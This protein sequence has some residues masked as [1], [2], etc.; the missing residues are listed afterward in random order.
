MSDSL[1][2][3]R[4]VLLIFLLII[5]NSSNSWAV[6][7]SGPV[8][9]KPVIITGRVTIQFEDDVATDKFQTGFTRTSFNLP[10]LDALLDQFGV[11]GAEAV[12]PWRTKKPAVNSKMYDL[13]RFWEI[14]FPETVDVNTVIKALI[15]NPH[16]RSAEAVW[17]IPVD[18]SPN[19]PGWVSQWYMH[20]PGP[21][22]HF[23]DAWDKETG[24]DSIIFACVDV[25]VCYRHPDLEGNIWVNPGEDMDSDGVVFDPDDLNGIDDD[26]NGRTDDLIG[27][28]FFS[29]FGGGLGIWPGEDPGSIDPDPNDFN[30]HGTNVSGIAVAMNNNATGVTGEAG[31]WYGGNRAFRGA[32]IMCCRVG[33]TAND[34]LGYV[35]SDNCG[36]AID[37]AAM[38]GASVINASWGSQATSTMI[39]GMNNATASGVS[40]FHAAG[41]ANLDSPDYLDLLGTRV[42]SVAATNSSDHKAGFSNFGTWVDVS[43]PG[44]DIWNTHSA[45]YTPSYA[46]Y[47]GTSMASPCAGGEALL[48]KSMMPSLAR[49]TIDS[50]IIVTADNI[51]ALNPSFIGQLGSGR[52]NANTALNLLANAKF[53]ADVTEGIAPLTVHFTDLSPNSPVS[54][55]WT[56]GTGDGSSSQNPIYIYNNPGIYT[57]SLKENENNVFGLGE[58]RLKNYIWVRNDAL[59]ID[60]VFGV[61]GTTKTVPVRLTNTSLTKSIQ[62]AF[63]MTATTGV[64]LDSFNLVGARTAYFDEGK[65]LV[66]NPSFYKWVISLKPDTGSGSTYLTSGSGVI[67]NLRFAID[68]SAPSG[69]ITID[70][71]TVSGR[72]TTVSSI[73]GDYFPNTYHAGKLLVGCTYGDAN[74]D[75]AV[76]NI[77]DL[78]FN[79]DYVFRG[80]PSTDLVGGDSNGDGFRNILDLTFL[81]D[82]IFRGGP[83]PP[84]PPP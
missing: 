13:T 9:P 38:M 60:S 56:F 43:A 50:L 24:S 62:F 52:I 15:Q 19:D 34:G 65:F 53:S 10:S 74:C 36:S 20:P 84:P 30:G 64:T 40:V 21:D 48:I 77:L 8:E 68:L 79:V 71:Q 16:V 4:S 26:G 33:A 57:V 7:V 42:M 81:V 83:P 51:D 11:T 12:F 76:A 49:T 44:Q 6:H 61:K 3:L 54:W 69:Y 66:K 45:M 78:T 39:A 80:G 5:L 25:G 23:Y 22:P 63:N 47:S 70:T 73:W 75:G 2:W 18:A 31:G 41:N 46:L 67:L 58:E 28:D 35:N 29:G 72:K 17:A 32:R 55:N 59:H 1:G 37:Y 82:R 27:Y 14:Y